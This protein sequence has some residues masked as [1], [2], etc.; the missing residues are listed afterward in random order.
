MEDMKFYFGA[1]IEWDAR[2]G[3]YFYELPKPYE[4]RPLLWLD[5]IDVLALMAASRFSVGS[6]GFPLGPA[7]VKALKKTAPLLG[8]TVTLQPEALDHV[9]FTTDDSATEADVARF[10]L[11]CDAILHRRELRLSYLKPKAGAAPETRIVHPLHIVIVPD[12]CIV[13]VH[14]TASAGRRNFDLARIQACELT[15]ATI[16]WPPDFDLQKYFAGGFGRFIGE[17]LHAVRPRLRAPCAA[18]PVATSASPHD[19]PRRQRGDDLLRESHQRVGATHPRRRRPSRS[20]QPA[21]N[22]PTPPRIRP[23]P[24]GP[25]RG[26]RTNDATRRGRRVPP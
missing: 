18:D 12:G 4:L 22:P 9:F 19:V 8:G 13:I 24:R 5:A 2:R 23:R 17:P 26:S 20:A 7:L 25:A 14:D 21:R 1:P 10:A 16:E 6:H 15:G 11:L 3:T